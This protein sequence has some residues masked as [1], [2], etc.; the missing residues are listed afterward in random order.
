MSIFKYF[1]IEKKFLIIKYIIVNLYFKYLK[2]VVRL[3]D[4]GNGRVI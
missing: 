3:Y 1:K 4:G 2:N